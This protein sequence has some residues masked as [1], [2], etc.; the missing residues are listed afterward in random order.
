M[1][2]SCNRLVIRA[3]DCTFC[4]LPKGRMQYTQV[5]DIDEP[6]RWDCHDGSVD[7]VAGGNGNEYRYA[8][9]YCKK[10]LEQCRFCEWQHIL[11]VSPVIVPAYD[12]KL[13]RAKELIL[14]AKYC[15]KHRHRV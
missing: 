15:V 1:L 6:Y 9:V 13:G 11:F 7:S 4:L 12:A 10:Y 14:L 8:A 3:S 2:S 5:G